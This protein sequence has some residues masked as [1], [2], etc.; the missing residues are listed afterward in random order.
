MSPVAPVDGIPDGRCVIDFAGGHDSFLAVLDDRSAVTWGGPT[1]AFE[2]S[3]GVGPL[4]G[5]GQPAF[6]NG[7]FQQC[8]P[9]ALDPVDPTL[10]DYAVSKSLWENSVSG[11][12][13]VFNIPL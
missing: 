2:F 1:S 3:R 9:F 5:T 4:C 8:T 10:P 13:P 12:L 11:A 6:V 7:V